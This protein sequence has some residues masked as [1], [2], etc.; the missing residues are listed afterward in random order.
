M[1][2]WTSSSV[3][4]E[5][6]HKAGAFVMCCRP[7]PRKRKRYVVGR[8]DQTGRR[9]WFPTMRQA[10]AYLGRHKDQGAVQAGKFYIDGPC[11]PR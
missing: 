3:D 10:V 9:R 7:T 1:R 8:W 2:D 4:W 11:R 5:A 6:S